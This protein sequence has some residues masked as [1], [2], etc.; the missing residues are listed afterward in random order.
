MTQAAIVSGSVAGL[1]GDVRD[2]RQVDGHDG[3]RFLLR[4]TG[5]GREYYG[6]RGGRGVRRRPRNSR[7]SMYPARVNHVH[8]PMTIAVPVTWKWNSVGTMIALACDATPDVRAPTAAPVGFSGA[9]GLPQSRLALGCPARVARLDEVELEALLGGLRHLRAR[10]D[11]LDQQPRDDRADERDDGA[12][13]QLVLTASRNAVCTAGPA[14]PGIPAPPVA[15]ASDEPV[16]LIGRGA[17]QQLGEPAAAERRDER[18]DDGDA[19]RAADHAAHR[20]HA[21][22]GAGLRLVDRVHRGGAHRRHHEAHADAHESEGERERAVRRVRRQEALG[23]Q[24]DRDEDQPERH[25][26]PRADPVRQATG[27]RPHDDDHE[28][29]GQ[30]AHARLERAVAAHVL[31]VER[32]EEEHRE[33]RE[34]DD[35]RDD[36][37]AQER[38]RAEVREVEHRGADVVLDDEEGDEARPA[39]AR[40]GR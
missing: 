8:S 5:C 11:L 12:D 1:G 31:H 37:R 36:V 23:E 14:L 19:E 2:L 39:R 21:G 25:E 30:E 16:D 33:H 28:R 10:R 35:E 9:R 24:R 27:D 18:A 26:R 40:T 17:G 3:V 15:R 32:E 7:M 20:E 29:R 4:G 34:A 38:A 13:L 6:A 22:R